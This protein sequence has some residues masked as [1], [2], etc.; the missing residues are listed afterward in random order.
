MARISRRSDQLPWRALRRT[1]SG[2]R[3]TQYLNATL[4]GHCKQSVVNFLN[5]LIIDSAKYRAGLLDPGSAT[6]RSKV[7]VVLLPSCFGPPIAS[8]RISGLVAPNRADS[9]RFRHLIPLVRSLNRAFAACARVR[10]A[11]GWL[12]LAVRFRLAKSAKCAITSTVSRLRTERGPRLRR[13]AHL[14]TPSTLPTLRVMTSDE[15]WPSNQD[16]YR[17]PGASPRRAQWR[18]A[19]FQGMVQSSDKSRSGLVC[20]AG[21]DGLIWPRSDDEFWPHPDDRINLRGQL[22]SGLG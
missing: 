11:G 1:L 3:E 15:Q 19:S 10:S 7:A 13:I 21:N 6:S 20:F 4:C 12:Y 16:R 8:D 18:A 22:L 9:G 14:D 2:D 5:R 17:P